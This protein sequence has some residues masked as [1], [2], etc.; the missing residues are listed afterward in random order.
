M[1]QLVRACALA[2]LVACTPP[3]PVV[4]VPPKEADGFAATLAGVQR[5]ASF[6]SSFDGDFSE[7]MALAQNNELSA[8]KIVKANGAAY[9]GLALAY[10]RFASKET[11]DECVQTL[12]G[13]T[14]P[15]L[16]AIIK[17]AMFMLQAAGFAWF[18]KADFAAGVHESRL[19]L[20]YR[21][22]GF[23]EADRGIIDAWHQG[24]GLASLRRAIDLSAVTSPP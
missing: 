2:W 21:K 12:I 23:T 24:L 4:V 5:T 9:K 1:M 13:K 19:L 22:S 20:A 14:D 18:S 10:F 16:R 17:T 15:N 11:M 8:C 3:K 6:E 7:V